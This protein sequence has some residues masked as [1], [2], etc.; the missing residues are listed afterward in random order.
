MLQNLKRKINL[1]LKLKIEF[2]QILKEKYLKFYDKDDLN[3]NI[4]N[5][6]QIE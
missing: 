5:L 6:K 1:K 2:L 3:L 4:T